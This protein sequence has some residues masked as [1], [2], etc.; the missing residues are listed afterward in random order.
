MTNFLSPSIGLK[1]DK[2]IVYHMLQNNPN[3]KIND[4]QGPVRLAAPTITPQL[5]TNRLLQ[6][7]QRNY[8]NVD[9]FVWVKV[10]D[11]A[12]I[13]DTE[14]VFFLLFAKIII[15]GVMLWIHNSDIALNFTPKGRSTL[16]THSSLSKNKSDEELISL[17]LALW[18]KMELNLE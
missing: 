16:D 17:T 2:A 10:Q 11:L 14:N 7:F 12:Q 1:S 5:S 9:I 4:D 6:T 8:I 13:F 18:I 3:E 15:H